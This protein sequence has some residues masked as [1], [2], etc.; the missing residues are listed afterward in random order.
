MEKILLILPD[1]NF[2][3]MQFVFELIK[4]SSNRFN[5]VHLLVPEDSHELENF[6]AMNVTVHCFKYDTRSVRQRFCILLKAIAVSRKNNVGAIFGLNQTGVFVSWIVSVIVRVKYYYLNDEL[7]VIDKK[8]KVNNRLR[9]RLFW[10]FE[11][12]GA[13]FST[14]IITQDRWR[15]IALKKILRLRGKTIIVLPNTPTP[16]LDAERQFFVRHLGLTPN[17]RVVLHMGLI[18]DYKLCEQL[19]MNVNE[20]DS[21]AV[22]VFYIHRDEKKSLGFRLAERVKELAKTDRE[23]RKRVFIIDGHVGAKVLGDIISS[24]TIGLAFYPADLGHNIR[25]MG[26]ASGRVNSYIVNAVPCL[27]TDLVGLRWIRRLH[28]GEVCSTSVYDVLKSAN[29]MLRNLALYQ[30]GCQNVAASELNFNKH[31]DNLFGAEFVK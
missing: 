11:K 6:R 25:L 14:A 30:R 8:G 18:H 5:G 29:M 13:S 19:V 4:K 9:G 27:A 31:L 2:A 21:N 12:I 24:A 3:F 17:Q 26:F 15:G 23:I 7:Y 20:L 28:A 10:I 16:A 22:L 1:P